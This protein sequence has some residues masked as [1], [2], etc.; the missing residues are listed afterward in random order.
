MLAEKEDQSNH[1]C[2]CQLNG[3]FTC[4]HDSTDAPQHSSLLHG[5]LRRPLDSLGCV[6]DSVLS[7]N[8][9]EEDEVREDKNEVRE[10]EQVEKDEEEEDEE[11]E[12][13]EG[14]K[15]VDISID[16]DEGL[17]GGKNEAESVYSPALAAPKI[18]AALR[19]AEQE[20]VVGVCQ[21]EDL[22]SLDARA[23]F[24]GEASAENR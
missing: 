1:L 2:D 5:S 4:D 12:E 3:T 14:D 11:E 15:S 13:G 16:G 18:Q 10:K 7:E 22:S 23:G 21:P 24:S 8:D 19:A 9:E 17:D 20:N 6:I